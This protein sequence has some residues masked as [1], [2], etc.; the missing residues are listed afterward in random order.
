[1]HVALG[2]RHIQNACVFMPC[3]YLYCKSLGICSI[4]LLGN[5]CTSLLTASLAVTELAVYLSKQAQMPFV[6]IDWTQPQVVMSLLTQSLPS[7]WGQLEA[8]WP[9]RVI[10]AT[11][12]DVAQL[13]HSRS[14][15]AL[16]VCV[17]NSLWKILWH[18]EKCVVWL[19]G[20]KLHNNIKMLNNVHKFLINWKQLMHF[21]RS[22]YMTD[23]DLKC[24]YSEACQPHMSQKNSQYH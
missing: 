5:A 8:A 2:Q 24:C 3:V 12:C 22:V 17:E 20:Y 14:L 11:S 15:S 9:K 21:L 13:R 1:M 10:T 16:P 6:I 4:S 7:W 23:Y 19:H 18:K